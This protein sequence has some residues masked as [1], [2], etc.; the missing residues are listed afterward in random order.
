[1]GKPTQKKSPA[2]RRGFFMRMTMKIPRAHPIRKVIREIL[3]FA[4]WFHAL[5]VF[6]IIPIE[7]MG[8]VSL[9]SR[10]IYNAALIGFIFYYSYFSDS[11]WF[12]VA[13]DLFY[14]YF[15]PFVTAFR[16]MW[17]LSKS[18]YRF[19]KSRTVITPPGLILKTIPNTE[20]KPGQVA[21]ITGDTSQSEPD[22][23]KKTKRLWRP[24]T[25]F[26]LLWSVLIL[27]IDNKIFI[28]V[29]SIIALAGAAKA[30][31]NLWDL[32]GDTSSWF[33]KL[34]SNFAAQMAEKIATVRM[35]EGLEHEKL[36]ADVNVLKIY[37]SAFTFIDQNRNFLAKF[38]IAVA[39]CITIPFY[40]YVSI[41]FSLAYFGISKVESIAWSWPSA[42][43]TSLFMPFAFTNLPRSFMIQTLGGL[44]AVAVTLMGWNIVYRNVS[45]KFERIATAAIELRIPFEESVYQEK[46]QMFTQAASLSASATPIAQKIKSTKTNENKK[47]RRES[48]RKRSG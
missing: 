23:S 4:F 18:G 2:D 1:M 39:A 25:Q 15:W 24:L 22:S 12:S 48:M 17:I 37:Q 11:G 6:H 30:M 10:Y 28:C 21:S 5:Y 26:N 14:I 46:L 31:Y 47:V 43:S 13:Y 40:C 44:H 41:L 35:W 8:I 29:A 9:S 42:L 36:T 45:N 38:T 34:K 16:C 7:Y 19:L 32:L 3:A 20:V 27:T 33:D